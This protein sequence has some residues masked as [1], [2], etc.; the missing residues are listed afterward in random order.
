MNRE[1]ISISVV[2]FVVSLVSAARGAP[3]EGLASAV[4]L[5]VIYYDGV[6]DGA[7]V[8]GRISVDA[9]NPL[10]TATGGVPRVSYTWAPVIENGPNWNRVDL[11]FV[12][13]GYT[14]GELGTYATN[15]GNILPVF[16]DEF[17]FSAYASYFNAYRVDV[18]SNQSGV[19]N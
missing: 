19:D 10:H 16:L 7:L 4:K 12:G 2:L 5:A 17:P 14:A 1:S 9:S 18:T 8:G 13:D 6:E 15:V 3:Q 11:V